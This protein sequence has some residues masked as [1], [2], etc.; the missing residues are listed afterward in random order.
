MSHQ[1]P[2]ELLAMLSPK[3]MSLTIGS[4]GIAELTRIDVAGAMGIAESKDRQAVKIYLAAYGPKECVPADIFD[5]ISGIQLNEWRNRAE[6]LVHAQ[7]AEATAKRLPR[8]QREG[9]SVVTGLKLSGARA[10]MWPSLTSPDT[11]GTWDR[12]VRALLTEMRASRACSACQGR[13]FLIVETVHKTCPECLGTGRVRVSDRQRAVMIGVASSTYHRIWRQ[14]YD[15]MYRYLMDAASRGRE[16][17][18][19]SVGD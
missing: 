16:L 12:M 3:S 6:R 13:Q 2:D 19:G 10:A 17:F 15:W 11:S 5:I 8:G 14:P 1:N 9:A 4:G 7:L 18:A